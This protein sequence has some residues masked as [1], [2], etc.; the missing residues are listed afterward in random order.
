MDHL[1]SSEM[2]RIYGVKRKVRDPLD[3]KAQEE[4]RLCAS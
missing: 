2:K 3:E 4:V 1:S